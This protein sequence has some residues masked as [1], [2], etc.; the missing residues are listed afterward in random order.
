MYCV[1]RL[2]FSKE[3]LV[4]NQSHIRDFNEYQF[5]NRGIKLNS[6]QFV[7]YSTEENVEINFNVP[8]S[9]VFQPTV[10]SLYEALLQKFFGKC[11]QPYFPLKIVVMKRNRFFNCRKSSRCCRFCE[12]TKGLPK[13]TQLWSK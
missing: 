5:H 13:R 12:S 1:V 11:R 2:K 4:I 3:I 6:K 8:V 10:P 9:R 7:F